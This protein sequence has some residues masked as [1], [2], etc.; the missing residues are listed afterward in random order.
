MRL[1]IDLPAE[2]ARALV[3]LGERA[4]ISLEEC[5]RRAVA[6]FI[7]GERREDLAAVFGAWRDKAIDG[8]EYQRELRAE[9]DR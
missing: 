4:G 2:E 9:W 7:E 6:H 1:E 3:E 5:V 8:V